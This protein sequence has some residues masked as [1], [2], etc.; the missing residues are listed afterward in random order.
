MYYP[1]HCE[2]AVKVRND[3]TQG[4]IVSVKH[5]CINGG[6]HVCS[7]IPVINEQYT[8]EIQIHIMHVFIIIHFYPFFT[9]YYGCCGDDNCNRYDFIHNVSHYIKF[10]F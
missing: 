7:D 4:S 5:S 6:L 1:V 3:V 2:V 9:A 8:S 10:T